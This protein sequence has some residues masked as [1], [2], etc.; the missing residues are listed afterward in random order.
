MA[1]RCEMYP[2]AD[3]ARKAAEAL[4]AQG[5]AA[6]ELRVLIGTP[7]RDV[8]METVGAFEG[9]VAPEG[10][11]GSFA[12]PGEG[13][14]DAPGSFSGDRSQ[15]RQ[16]SFG[17]SEHDEVVSFEGGAEHEHTVDRHTLTKLLEQASNDHEH[18][19]MLVKSLH[20]GHAV[21]LI[22]ITG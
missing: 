20:D 2:T 11:V 5:T 13:R 14:V 19:E 8:R 16:G 22:G 9:T 3:E 6:E 10:H 7:T 12:G 1:A 17:D 15:R 4:I 18:A 21:L